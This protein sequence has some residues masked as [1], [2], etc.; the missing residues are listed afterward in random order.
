MIGGEEEDK[1]VEDTVQEVIM[2]LQT[3]SNYQTHGEMKFIQWLKKWK[4]I[5]WRK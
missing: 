4:S 2:Q 1:E 3:Q 5:S